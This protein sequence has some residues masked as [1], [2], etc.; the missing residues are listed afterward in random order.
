VRFGRLR[1]RGALSDDGA[2]AAP[3]KT[4]AKPAKATPAKPDPKPA[5]AAKPAPAA[6][7]AKAKPAVNPPDAAPVKGKATIADFVAFIGEQIAAGEGSVI[8]SF[9]VNQARRRGVDFDAAISEG[10][11]TVFAADDGKEY[12]AEASD[13]DAPAEIGSSGE[14][15]IGGH[16]VGRLH[17]QR[18]GRLVASQRVGEHGLGVEARA[19]A[20]EHDQRRGLV[21]A[22]ELARLKGLPLEEVARATTRNFIELF[23]PDLSSCTAWNPGEGVVHRA[24]KAHA[25]LEIAHGGDS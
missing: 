5:A 18:G 12:V 14:V 9:L 23:R 1:L 3:A 4:P 22:A 17:Q 21:V 19:I 24:S 10:G 13:E 6:T 25:S 20:A 11:F 2:E 15:L 7:A 16:P 8:K